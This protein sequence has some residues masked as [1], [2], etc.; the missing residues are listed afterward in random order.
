MHWSAGYGP[1]SALEGTHPG[2]LHAAQWA[3][4]HAAAGRHAPGLQS[5]LHAQQ[6]VLCPPAGGGG[7][8]PGLVPSG[9]PDMPKISMSTMSRPGIAWG[10]LHGARE[11]PAGLWL[12]LPGHGDLGACSGK[13]S[14]AQR[15]LSQGFSTAIQ[16]AR[17]AQADLTSPPAPCAPGCSELTALRCCSIS[18]DTCHT[19]SGDINRSAGHDANQALFSSLPHLK[20]LAFWW[21]MRV[22]SSLKTR[23]Q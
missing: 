7:A 5:R 22:L 9:T 17:T 23:S 10:T 3:A 20:C 2:W 15:G 8:C 4:M 6:A 19:C 11:H 13:N 16:E 14:A 18:C 1:A 12:R 21:V